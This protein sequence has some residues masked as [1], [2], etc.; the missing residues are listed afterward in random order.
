MY[1]IY[2]KNPPQGLR[3]PEVTSDTDLDLTL[4]GQQRKSF[5]GV[6]L[7]EEK[8]EQLERQTTGHF[9]KECN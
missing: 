6:G 2:A 5:L 4:M 9:G 1:K 3:T 8:S 7:R